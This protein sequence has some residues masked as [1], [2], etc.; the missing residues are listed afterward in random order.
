MF[1]ITLLDALTGRIAL[2][3][4][5]SSAA[6]NLTGS[7]ELLIDGT[8]A[9]S[10]KFLSGT[11]PPQSEKELLLGV[12]IPSTYPGEKIHLRV[13]LGDTQRTFA[14][15]VYM[16]KT[17]PPLPEYTTGIRADAAQ[18][19]ISGG[20]LSALLTAN[21][22][23]ELRFNGDMLLAEM[24]R[25]I[26]YQGDAELSDAVAAL[27]LDRMR[28]SADRFGADETAVECHALALPRRMDLDELEFTQRFVPLAAEA[29]RYEV[30]F[31]V[32][33]SFAGIPR[34]GVEMAL[35]GRFDTVTLASPAGTGDAAGNFRTLPM[36]FAAFRDDS[37]N[38]LLI[39]A[40]GMPLLLSRSAFPEYALLGSSA[41]Q[42]DG[43]IHLTV[44]C[45]NHSCGGSAV[46]AGRFRMAMIFAPLCNGDNAALKARRLQ[47]AQF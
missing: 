30:E 46:A 45:R 4:C 41:P 28:I 33:E 16:L 15:P 23:R 18:A 19:I 40:A 31:I 1:E 39:A 11:L 6:G 2:R 34:L 44:D 22:M 3:N 20:K 26:L 36:E 9:S 17:F 47:T 43:K 7:W 12:E 42:P 38:G 32:P 21:G 10:G 14:L 13:T 37:G 24:P 25:L 8:T 5:G 29:I 27:Q 35:P